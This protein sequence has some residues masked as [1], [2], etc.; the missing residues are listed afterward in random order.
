MAQA[1]GIWAGGSERERWEFWGPEQDTD[2][3]KL[4]ALD[5]FVLIL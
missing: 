1:L 4:L 2:A 5:V 3:V